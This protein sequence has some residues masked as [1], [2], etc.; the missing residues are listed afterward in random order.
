MCVLSTTY[1][2]LSSA[3]CAEILGTDLRENSLTICKPNLAIFE[4]NGTDTQEK[5]YKACL[6]PK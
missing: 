2:P 6:T 4:P 5:P 1:K 3:V